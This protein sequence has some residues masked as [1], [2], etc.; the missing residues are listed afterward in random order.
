MRTIQEQLADRIYELLPEKKEL[1]F[2]CEVKF[3]FSSARYCGEDNDWVYLEVLE[4]VRPIKEIQKVGKT[5][6]LKIIGQPIRL[7][8]LLLAISEEYGWIYSRDVRKIFYNY[9]LSRDNILEQSDEFC[10]FALEIL[11][12]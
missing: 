6:A 3:G 7:A 1:G 8:D 12:K 2:G 4:P 11:N 10:K 9:D 5:L